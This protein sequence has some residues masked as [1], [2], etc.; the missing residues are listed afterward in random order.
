[1]KI[2]IDQLHKHPKEEIVTNYNN[3]QGRD[4]LSTARYF[5]RMAN[6]LLVEDEGFGPESKGFVM[7]TA[8]LNVR[9]RW[10]H[11]GRGAEDFLRLITDNLTNCTPDAAASAEISA[12]TATSNPVSTQVYHSHFL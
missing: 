4:I 2:A 10:C 11:K 8:D 1:V 7:L 3:A 9:L 12:A 5:V 6:Q